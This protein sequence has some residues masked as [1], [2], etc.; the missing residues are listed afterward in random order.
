MIMFPT[1]FKP[2]SG[3][4]DAYAVNNAGDVY[5]KLSNRVLAPG[6]G[7]KGY[8]T[9][10][11]LGKTFKV[12]RLVATAFIANTA[13]KPSVNHMDGIKTN[14]AQCN[15]EWVTASENLAHRYRVLG[16]VTHFKG[17]SG[18]LH[19][20]SKPVQG[21]CVKTGQTVHFAGASDAARKLGG[22]HY[23]AISAVANGR[24]RTA[25]GYSWTWAK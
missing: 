4:S 5:S 25:Y 3:Y 21:V 13:C 19:A 11:L 22:V 8:L 24:G 18:A 10:S 7:A 17:R 2:I 9:V 1:G 14:N 16:Q 23:T 15:L 12:H 20:Q 6:L